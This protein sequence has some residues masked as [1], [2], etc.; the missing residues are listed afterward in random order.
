MPRTAAR[1]HSEVGPMSMYEE[2]VERRYGAGVTYAAALHLMQAERVMGAQISGVLRSHG[3]SW[4]QWSTLTM[5]HL[6]PSDRV[7]LGKI[8]KSLEVHATTITNAVDRLAELGLVERLT[9]PADRRTVLAAVTPAGSAK[10]DEVMHELAE[11]KFGL[12][13]LTAGELHT[14]AALL[15]K[16]APLDGSAVR[17]E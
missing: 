14:L 12:A 6:V 10:A 8:A 17:P 13:A 2:V 9:D 3:L 16:I 4:P 1:H 15:A 11:Q 7:H 5:V